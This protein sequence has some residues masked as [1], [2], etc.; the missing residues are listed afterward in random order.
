MTDISE[1]IDTYLA[2]WNET[3][4]ERRMAIVE[5]VWAPGRT[6]DRSS[7]GH[8][9]GRDQRDGCHLPVPVPQSPVRSSEQDR[10]TPQ[11][12]P[13]CLGSCGGRRIGVSQWPRRG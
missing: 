9:T 4:L 1:T 7:S 10:R 8:R 2:G 3:D 11:S 6:L 12:L 13:L 5:R